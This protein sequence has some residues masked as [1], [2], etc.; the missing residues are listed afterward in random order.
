MVHPNHNCFPRKETK[1]SI[2]RSQ[3]PYIKLAL[4][5]LHIFFIQASMCRACCIF[6]WIFLSV[7]FFFFFCFVV[8]VWWHALPG[9]FLLFPRSS[10]Q[11]MNVHWPDLLSVTSE[12]TPWLKVTTG[13][14]WQCVSFNPKGRQ[15]EQQKKGGKVKKKER[16]SS[17]KCHI[18]TQTFLFLL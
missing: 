6:M 11:K 1:T 8:F 16:P 14:A 17:I 3:G 12:R 18:S 10:W 5:S 7:M 9:D 15:K 13:D 2:T 4:S